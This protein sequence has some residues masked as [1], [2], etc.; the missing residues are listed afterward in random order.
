MQLKK[1][2]L[3]DLQAR[4]LLNLTVAI[5]SDIF[6]PKAIDREYISQIGGKYVRLEQKNT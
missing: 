5:S 1:I 6:I 4:K 2:V 3:S